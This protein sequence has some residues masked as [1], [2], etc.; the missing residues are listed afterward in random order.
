MQLLEGVQLVH[1]ETGDCSLQ[2]SSQAT[3]VSLHE[4]QQQ[5]GLGGP[6]L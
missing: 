6:L 2:D 1:L 4:H 5:G 3:N